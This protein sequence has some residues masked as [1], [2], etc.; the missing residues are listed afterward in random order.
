MAVE[1][2][3]PSVVRGEGVTG[4]N[5]AQTGY[6][7]ETQTKD[8]VDRSSYEFLGLLCHSGQGLVRNLDVRDSHCKTAS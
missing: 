8:A 6:F 4:T 3:A 2:G 7:L 1:K 5:L